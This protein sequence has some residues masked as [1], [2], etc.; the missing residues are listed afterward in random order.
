L[1]FKWRLEGGYEPHRVEELV[2]E[3]WET[4]GVY[5]LVKE[6]SE[7]NNVFFNFIDGPPYP[8]GDVPHIGTAWNK[9][10]KDAVLR[11]KRM[12]GFRVNDK[13]GY[14]CHGLPIEVKVEQKLGVR[15]K[16]EI[17][18]KI[19]IDRFVEECKK[20][21][22]SNLSAMTHWFKELGVFMDWNNP[23]LTLRDEYIE[24]EWW[25]I[26]KAEEQG[27]LDSEYRVV[28]WCPRCSTTLM[29]KT[30]R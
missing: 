24:A 23:Y 20:F 28:Y 14:D 16:K 2:K 18:E 30:Q 22:L 1:E 7:K 11:F 26:K 21:A 4:S 3:Y 17:E 13:P 10:L 8:S 19:G 9:A 6:K 15:F 27:L 29:G 5:K 25:L 12:K